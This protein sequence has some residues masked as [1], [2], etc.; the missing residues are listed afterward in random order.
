MLSP[1]PV[2]FLPVILWNANS[3][4]TRDLFFLKYTCLSCFHNIWCVL[5]FTTCMQMRI[6]VLFLWV[7]NKVVPASYCK[8]K[9]GLWKE[10][11][12]M[13]SWYGMQV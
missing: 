4:Q 11:V 10:V 2:L 6:F 8:R 13:D 3:C 7:G 9:P 5:D 1:A 12:Y